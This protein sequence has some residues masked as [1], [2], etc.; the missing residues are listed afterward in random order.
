[1][2]SNNIY[3][4]NNSSYNDNSYEYS[5]N[6][7]SNLLGL[8]N[9]VISGPILPSISIFSRQRDRTPIPTITPVPTYSEN[10][11][12][13]KEVLSPD[14]IKNQLENLMSQFHPLLDEYNKY[15][16]LNNSYSTSSNNKNNPDYPFLYQQ[17]KTNITSYMENLD[18]YLNTIQNNIQLIN[19]KVYVLNEHIQ[20]DKEVTKNAEEKLDDIKSKYIGTYEMNGDF[21]KKYND[22]YLSMFTL[23]IATILLGG[24]LVKLYG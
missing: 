9:S 14:F 4:S 1:M 15:Y 7:W 22:I 17:S 18:T 24:T 3:N 8:K 19:S 13:A 10:I 16:K 23:S 20:K 6:I 2:I 12:N 21:N 11:S 5:S